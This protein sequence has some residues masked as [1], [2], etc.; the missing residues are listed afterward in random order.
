MNKGFFSLRQRRD[1]CG[2]LHLLLSSVSNMKQLL[3]KAGYLLPCKAVKLQAGNERMPDE[4][5]YIQTSATEIHDL[6]L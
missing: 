6:Q 1:G 3:N 5:N 2:D 4:C